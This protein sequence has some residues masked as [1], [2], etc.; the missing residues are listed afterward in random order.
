MTRKGTRGGGSGDGGDGK[1]PYETHY[2]E[3]VEWNAVESKPPLTLVQLRQEYNDALSFL[4]MLEQRINRMEE[5]EAVANRPKDTPPPAMAK[6]FYFSARAR[7][8]R[9]NS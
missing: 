8:H 1:K 5:L 3:F 7:S 9:D 2:G 4:L 6:L